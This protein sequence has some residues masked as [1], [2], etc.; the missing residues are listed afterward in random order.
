MAGAVLLRWMAVGMNGAFP[1][2]VLGDI[3]GFAGDA[4]VVGADQL[5]EQRLVEQLLA[6][7]AGEPSEEHGARE[8]GDEQALNGRAADA[9][10]TSW[11]SHP[12]LRPHRPVCWTR[13][14]SPYQ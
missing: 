9:A 6:R 5:G 10:G 2:A 8:H 14:P 4:V 12:H 13:L 1:G 7:M 3:G 11:T